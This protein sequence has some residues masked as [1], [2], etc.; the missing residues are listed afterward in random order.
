MRLAQPAR[1]KRSQSEMA[2]RVLP[3][4]VACTSSARRNFC[5]KRSLT[6]LIASSWYMRSAMARFGATVAS[7]FLFFRWCSRYSRLSFE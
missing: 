1:I 4:P 6:R 7:D 3:V 2:T 5:S